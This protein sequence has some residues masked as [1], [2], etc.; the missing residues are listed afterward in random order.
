[1]AAEQQSGAA[2]RSSV[3][4]GIDLPNSERSRRR[5]REALLLVAK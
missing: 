3:V 2:T 4:V 1:M 5:R